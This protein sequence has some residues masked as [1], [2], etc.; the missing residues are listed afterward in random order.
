[1]DQKYRNFWATDVNK[2]QSFW[3]PLLLAKD[4]GIVLKLANSAV[5]VVAVVAR[6]ARLCFF[7]FC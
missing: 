4:M 2:T 5:P 3:A 7:T 6:L 1:M